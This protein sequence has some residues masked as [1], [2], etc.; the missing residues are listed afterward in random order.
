VIP[1]AVSVEP[2]T[3]V[4]LTEVDPASVALVA[5]SMLIAL[6]INRA[7][8]VALRVAVVTPILVASF[9]TTVGARPVTSKLPLATVEREYIPPG[10]PVAS[11]EHVPT[12]RM[13]TVVPL[14]VHTLAVAVTV[15]Y[16]SPNPTLEVA[17]PKTDKEVVAI[18]VF[19]SG[20]KV[21][22]CENTGSIEIGVW[23]RVV[24]PVPS[25]ICPLLREP[26]HLMSTPTIAQ[27]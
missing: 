26:Q 5:Y 10:L 18:V 4:P 24:S 9:V 2:V 25:P 23:T 3:A 27:L 16:V 1:R 6:V 13:V 15:V 20:S 22:D 21:T 14:T 17:L 7:F 11:T 8:T 19:E 12:P